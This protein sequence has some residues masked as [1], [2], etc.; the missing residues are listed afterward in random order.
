MVKLFRRRSTKVGTP[1]GSLIYTGDEISKPS[2]LRAIFFDENTYLEKEVNSIEEA[3]KIKKKDQKVWLEIT[4]VSDPKT[5]NS[6]GNFLKLHPLL[7]EDIMSPAQRSKLDD[8]R[9][10]IYIATRVLRFS[11]PSDGILEDEQLSIVLNSELLITFVEKECGVL[12][13]I[14]ER[15]KKPASRMRQKGVDYL[16]YAILDSI[17]DHYFLALERVDHTL[18]GLE[19]EL[20]TDPKPNTLFTIQKIKREMALLRKII[21]PTRE[22]INHFRRIE[23]PLIHNATKVYAYDVY[24]HT[25]QAIETVESFRDVTSGMIDI[26]LSTINQ[27]M[28]EIMKVLTVVATIFVPLT[29]ITSLY[30][31]N[32]KAMPELDSEWGYPLVLLAMAA[33]TLLMLWFFRRKRW[34]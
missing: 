19:E 20:L 1:P 31:M 11:S 21:W 34:I 26:Y 9:D 23:S 22:L 3:L 25:I 29:F 33:I 2:E 10:Y 15:L 30:G 14:R 5:I 8:Y 17:V 4:G 16:A 32:F 13:P 24:D 28:N 6:I 12:A 18:E 27:K 7:L